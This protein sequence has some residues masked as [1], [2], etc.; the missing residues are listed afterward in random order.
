MHLLD[1]AV[2]NCWLIHRAADPANKPVQ[3]FDYRFLMGEQLLATAVADSTCSDTDDGGT[4]RR[5]STSAAT[6]QLQQK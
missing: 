1:L 2:N 6:N 4:K 3:L 5:E